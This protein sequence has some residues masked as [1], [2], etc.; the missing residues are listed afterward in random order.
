[1][2]Q[3]KQVKNNAMAKQKYEFTIN[4]DGMGMYETY[5]IVACDITTAKKKA[6]E[7]A[8]ADFK[9]SLKTSLEAKVKIANIF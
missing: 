1:L 5:T 8:V 7:K 3:V 6:K 2:Y 4:V 9:R